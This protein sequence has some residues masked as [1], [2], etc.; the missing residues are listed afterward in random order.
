MNNNE[1]KD[2]IIAEHGD[3]ADDTTSSQTN[4]KPRV[5]GRANKGNEFRCYV[6]GK[7]IAYKDF[8]DNNVQ[9]D[10]TPDTEFTVESYRYAHKPCL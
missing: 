5:I 6:C 1:L 8:D 4:A 10:F 9:V 2:R 7:F 3:V